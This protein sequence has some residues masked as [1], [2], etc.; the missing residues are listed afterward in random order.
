MA[1]GYDKFST[2]Q[3]TNQAMH[4]WMNMT[5]QIQMPGIVVDIL[6]R[7][8]VRNVAIVGGG[9]ILT[10]LITVAYAPL[11]TRLYGP[12][13]FGV[14]GMF[15]AVL[16]VLV[17][18]AALA[19]PMAIP[20]PEEDDE[21]KNLENLSFLVAC[22]STLIMAGVIAACG[23]T[24]AVQ[25]GLERIVGYLFLVPPA[26]FATA[27][28]QIL[29]HSLIRKHQFGATAKAGVVHSLIINNAKWGLGAFHPFAGML[30][31]MTV[32]GSA[33]HAMLLLLASRAPGRRRKAWRVNFATAAGAFK[34]TAWKHGHFP[35][36][37][38]PEM[39]LSAL[40]SGL[41]VLLLASA[42]DAKTAGFYTLAKMILKVPNALFVKSVGDV[43]YARLAEA[44]RRRARLF[45]LV[46][47]ATG[48]LAAVALPPYLLICLLGPMLFSLAFGSAW[49][50]AGVYAQWMSIWLF[51]ATTSGA[52]IKTLSVIGLQR[53]FLVYR[54][55]AVG[56]SVLS[57]KVGLIYWDSG[58]AAVAAYSLAGS[59]LCMGLIAFVLAKTMNHDAR[60]NEE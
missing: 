29:Y 19:Y 27:M 1:V 28:V 21:V 31:G 20:L 12:D 45:P 58:V 38:A 3:P 49:R 44:K 55:L 41:P 33:V 7:G 36:Y 60:S 5:P 32:L 46:C 4:C 48:G 26:M 39:C 22:A 56:V 23:R 30:V 11:L 6:R 17:P 8:F 50:L 40:S 24:I 16:A 47:K 52:I 14:W 35:L 18:F 9:A 54:I 43:L 59:V 42:A 13:A 37:R 10:Q 2:R 25:L 57:I 34:E 53:H 51:F 15:K